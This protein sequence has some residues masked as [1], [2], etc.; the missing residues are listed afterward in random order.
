MTRRLLNWILELNEYDFD[1]VHIPGRDNVISD[2]LSRLDPVDKVSDSMF[3]ITIYRERYVYR[4][5]A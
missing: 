2:C 4:K 3:T 5:M 1:I